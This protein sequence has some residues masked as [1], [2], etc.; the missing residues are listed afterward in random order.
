MSRII[1]LVFLFVDLGLYGQTEIELLPQ[2]IILPRD[3]SSLGAKGAIRFNNSKNFFEGHDG[4]EWRKI[5]QP[6]SNQIVVITPPDLQAE[7]SSNTYVQSVSD[8]WFEAVSTTPVFL[9][10]I[11]IPTG[12][13]LDSLM[14]YY[15]DNAPSHDL[16][17]NILGY[18]VVAGVSFEL[19]DSYPA[20][21][22]SGDVNVFQVATHQTNSIPGDHGTSYFVKVTAMPSW[23]GS[24]IRIKRIEVFSSLQ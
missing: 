19:I 18:K 2:A 12:W 10:K 11:D 17:V 9:K 14:I 3:N 24:D 22:S 15:F 4:T 21:T 8:G 7:K 13:K 6:V 5:L 1:L 20:F 23:P 16:E